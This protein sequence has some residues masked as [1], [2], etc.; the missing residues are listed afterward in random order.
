MCSVNRT[1]IYLFFFFERGLDPMDLF[2]YV[3]AITRPDT[4]NQITKIPKN[5]VLKVDKFDF[6]FVY[7]VLKGRTIQSSRVLL[8]VLPTKQWL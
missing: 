5:R 3:P 4:F 7:V 1:L 8:Q 2:N 6:K